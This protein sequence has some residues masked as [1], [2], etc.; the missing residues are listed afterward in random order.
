[1]V[2]EAFYAPQHLAGWWGVEKSLITLHIGGVYTLAWEYSGKGVRYISSGVISDF[3]EGE[4]LTVE[5][6]VYVSP[7]K[8][9]LGPMSMQVSV[10]PTATGSKLKIIQDGYQDGDDWELYYD[11]VVTAWPKALQFLKNYLESL[12]EK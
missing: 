1:M 4:L 12:S 11:A 7:E 2:L 6:M 10:K 8:S 3:I 5:K 9:I